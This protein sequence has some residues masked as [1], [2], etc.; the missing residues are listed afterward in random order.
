MTA[1]ADTTGP[2][3]PAA[4][5][6][7]RRGPTLLQGLGASIWRSLEAVGH[8]R[9]ARELSLLAN[10]WTPFDPGLATTLREASR[11]EHRRADAILGVQP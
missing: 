11:D 5:L 8:R 10:R 6:G 1:L 9:A 7:R 3:G 2:A 4:A